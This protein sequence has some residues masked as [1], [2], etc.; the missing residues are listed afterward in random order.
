MLEMKLWGF[1]NTAKSSSS[2]GDAIHTIKTM[3]SDVFTK[4]SAIF[5][6]LVMH[7]SFQ[8]LFLWFKVSILILAICFFKGVC[9]SLEL[10]KLKNSG[11]RYF[12][13][14][15]LKPPC[16]SQTPKKPPWRSQTTKKPLWSQNHKKA[17]LEGKK[18]P[19]W[20]LVPTLRSPGLDKLVG[21][22]RP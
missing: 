11:L 4:A 18:A 9:I 1:F 8:T 15:R 14:W 5:I 6:P 13:A 20:V 12:V 7:I 10:K 16:R 22:I 21:L 2:A 3:S 19:L 17:P